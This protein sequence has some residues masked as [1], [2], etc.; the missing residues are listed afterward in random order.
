MQ[1]A[2]QFL[3]AGRL[4]FDVVSWFYLADGAGDHVFFVFEVGDHGFDGQEETGDGG[5]VLQGDAGHLGWVNDTGLDQVFVDTGAGVVAD[6]AFFAQHF[7]NHNGAVLTSVAG[8]L[9]GWGFDGAEDSF[10]TE[11][12]VTVEIG[13]HLFDGF[14]GAQ[15]G[16]TT[17]RNDAFFNGCTGGVQGVVDAILLL[18]HFRLGGSTD[19]DHGNTAGQLGQALLQLLFVVVGSG[20]FDLLTDLAD[21][22]LDVGLLASTFDDGGGFFFDGDLLGGTEVGQFNVFKLFT[23]VFGNEL[24]TGEDGDV[25]EHGLATVAKAWSL[26]RADIQG[27]AQLVDDQ[28]SQGFA[29]DVF[30]DDQQGLASLGNLFEQWQEFAQVADLLFVDEDQRFFQG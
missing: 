1:N 22:G 21:A 8:D 5:G 30:G 4:G 25:F 9:A 24:G 11:A 3:A 16:N 7:G 6:V 20:V 10:G 26:H 29:F 19:I 12:V 15:Q 23:E 13:D 28:G 27:A 14:L 17:T 2:L 18:F